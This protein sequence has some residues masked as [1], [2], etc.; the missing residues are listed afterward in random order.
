MGPACDGP[1]YRVSVERD[2]QRLGEV[3]LCADRYQVAPW[4]VA[5]PLLIVALALWWT[6][7]R[8]SRRILRPLSLVVRLAEDLGAGKLG[9]RAQMTC[10]WYGEERI[11]AESL[12][13]MADRIE[14]Q[15]ADQRELLAA[16]SHEMRTPLGHMRILTETARGGSLDERTL[17]ELDREIAEMDALVGDL[18][19]SSRLQFDALVPK[20]LD[21]AD[22]ARRALERAGLAP[23]LLVVEGDAALVGDA[24]LLG[25]ALANLLENPRRHAGGATRLV[26][27]REGELVRFAVED[28]GAGF[29]PGAEQKAF[30]AF[31]ERAWSSTGTIGLGLDLVR[32]IAHAHGGQ[33]LAENLPAKGARV[34]FTV[35]VSPPPPA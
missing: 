11:V 22:L 1:A 7:G 23:A 4:R 27:R 32:R 5:A 3:Q 13:R 2:G 20:P 31:R 25:R 9:A 6:A 8:L 30:E 16:V 18:L 15:L 10:Y 19:A 14:R 17:G 28:A 33:A 26:V 12:N 21:G 24:T 29:V 35:G 34:S